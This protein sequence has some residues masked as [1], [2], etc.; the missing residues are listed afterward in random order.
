MTTTAIFR[1]LLHAPAMSLLVLKWERCGVGSPT[2]LPPRVKRSDPVSDS[3]PT[4]CTA[5][6]F[7]LSV[8]V[9]PSIVVQKSEMADANGSPPPRGCCRYPR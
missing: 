7:G 5:T 9:V 4:F 1:G 2:R 3:L 6:G 8:L